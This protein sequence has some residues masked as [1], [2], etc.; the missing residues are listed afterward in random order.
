MTEKTT[1]INPEHKDKL[2]HVIELND[3]VAYPNHN[4]LEFGKVV[5]I[6]PKMVKVVRVTA[7]K[8]AKEQ[9]KYPAD[10]VKLEA[11]YMTWYL[12]NNS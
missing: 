10:M 8:N 6:N 11:K 7:K 2:G 9:N 1:K 5:K 4:A 3:Y 12:L